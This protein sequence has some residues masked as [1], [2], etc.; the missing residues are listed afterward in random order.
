MLT[1]ALKDDQGEKIKGENL[2]RIVRHVRHSSN[3]RYERLKRNWRLEA[4]DAAKNPH[5]YFDSSLLSC[6]DVNR[7]LEVTRSRRGISCPSF[8]LQ[9]SRPDYAYG[10]GNC[11]EQRFNNFDS[12][13]VVNSTK[14][15][16]TQ[17][18]SFEKQSARQI[19]AK[20]GSEDDYVTAEEALALQQQITGVG[21][22]R[23]DLV[24]DVRRCTYKSPGRHSL[25]FAKMST[26]EGQGMPGGFEGK[27]A[28]SKVT[29]TLATKPDDLSE[30]LRETQG[31]YKENVL[32]E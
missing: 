25:D 8:E 2:T 10:V 22:Y 1:E 24:K 3:T 31:W 18:V 15:R 28:A 16:R 6:T 27:K 21:S 32:G 11:S 20:R 5:R 12:N 17:A 4:D 23:N 19:R 9:T 7:D 30:V 14:F 26:R 29:H 13:K